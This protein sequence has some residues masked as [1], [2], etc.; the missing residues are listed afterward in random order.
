[1][2][3]VLWRDIPD[4]V[5]EIHRDRYIETADGF[6]FSFLVDDKVEEIGAMEVAFLV[7]NNRQRGIR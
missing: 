7:G 5:M 1:M 4:G 2:Y 6:F 3:R